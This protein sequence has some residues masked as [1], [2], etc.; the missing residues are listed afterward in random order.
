MQKEKIIKQPNLLI[1]KKQ[2]QNKW[3]ALTPDYKKLI[4]VGD[5][6]S[7]VLKAAK[8]SEKVVMKV[9]P[10]LGYAPVSI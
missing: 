4:A 1:L 2:H 9:L 7:A 10:R 8:Q 3:V 6:L 5:S